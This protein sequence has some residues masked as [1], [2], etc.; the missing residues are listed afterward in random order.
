[1][2]KYFNFLDGFRGVLCIWIVLFHFT[3]RYKELY[4]YS[5]GYDFGHGGGIR[6]NAFLHDFRFSYNVYSI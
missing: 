1:M 6:R 5:F 2:K 4:G 3:T